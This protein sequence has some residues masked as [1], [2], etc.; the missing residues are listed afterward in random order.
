MLMIM[1]KD[2]VERKTEQP[3]KNNTRHVLGK[4]CRDKNKT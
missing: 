1:F 3:Q 4:N 2:I